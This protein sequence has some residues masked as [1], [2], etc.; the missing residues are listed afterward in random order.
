MDQDLPLSALLGPK[1]AQTITMKRIK[2]LILLL[3]TVGGLT[4]T[5]SGALI[6]ITNSGFE[7]PI[8]AAGGWD[9]NLVDWEE[10][11]GAG[12]GDSFMENIPLF[13]SEGSN[14]VGLNN[15]YY[16]WQD[17]GVAWEAD[18]VYTLVVSAGY[19]AAQT[20]GTNSTFYAL[21]SGTTTLGAANSP[22]TADLATSAELQ[23]SMEWNVVGN[24]TAE[25]FGEAPALK[26][27][28]DATPPAGNIIILLGDNSPTGRSH[29]DGISLTVVSAFDSDGDGLPAD[30]EADHSLDDADDGSTNMDNGA[31]GDPDGDMRTNL[32]EFNEGTDPRDDDSDDDGST[33]GEEAD[34]GTNPNLEDTDEDGLKDGVEDLTGTWIDE[35]QTGTDPLKNDTD[36]DGL[37]DG[38]EDKGG[39][40]VDADQTGTDPNVAD[41]DGD[42]LPDGWEVTNTIDP[43]DDGTTNVE[44]GAAGDPDAD[45]SPNLREFTQTTNPRLDDSDSDTL[46]DGYED[47]G[48]VWV[49]ATMTGSDPLNGDTDGDSIPD[50]AETGDG[51][52]VD[53]NAT[54]TDPSLHDT[55]GDG[56]FD[57]QEI[58]Q[59]TDPSDVANKPAFPTPLGF[60]TFDDQGDTTTA[61]LSPN[62]NDGTLLGNTVYAAGHTGSAGDF[63]VELDGIDSAVTTTMTLNDIGAF[64]MAG[65]IKMTVEQTNRSGLFGQN[66]IL[67]F[68]FSAPGNVH[69]W[70]NPG[71]ALN[72]ALDTSEEWVHIAFVGD[73]SGRTIYFN[74]VEAVTG[75]A[76]TPLVASGS[77]FNIGGGGVFDATGNFFQGLIDDVGVWEVSMSP[78]LIKGL[79]D[80]TISPVP[81]LSSGLAISSFV[82]T[83]NSLAFTIQGTIPGVEYIIQ[84]SSTLTDDWTESI[85][86]V[87]A[88]GVGVTEVNLSLGASPLSKK[89]Y[90]ARILEE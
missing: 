17:T 77:F 11:D 32:Q 31:D 27:T 70:S 34:R 40:F 57:E 78:Q 84:E 54:G 23:A 56:Y 9:N 47:N 41:T 19:R 58:A 90:R 20:G 48:G 72:V 55:D 7:N 44:N 12:D 50:A 68:G 25:R 73:T 89:F 52:Y 22:T 42:E 75:P 60:W 5:S 13:S 37:L 49:S 14:H 6:E 79:A 36:E 67:E 66:D 83:D 4:T 3:G 87:G 30:W 69:L 59:G 21:M 53:G 35:N 24:V 26:F 82:R 16:V 61:D 33:D 38:V 65:W 46:L 29:F 15:G 86:F 10:R 85:D 8:L 1:T 80:G 43:N 64:T 28:T 74:G 39:I 2:Q 76:G 81:G 62:G 18:R 71:G 63:A 51:N 88:D 45:F